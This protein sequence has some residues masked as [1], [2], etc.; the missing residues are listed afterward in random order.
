MLRGIDQRDQDFLH[1][2]FNRRHL[3]THCGGKVDQEYLDK[4]GD[5]SVRLNEVP[6]V[7]SKEVRRLISLEE[8]MAINLL[9]GFD[10]IC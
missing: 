1:R 8:K 5:R 4:T 7:D 2:M 6:K 10:S 9:D 3:F